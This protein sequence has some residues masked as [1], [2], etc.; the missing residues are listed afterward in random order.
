L[1]EVIEALAVELDCVSRH[2]QPYSFAL[3]QKV[4]IGKA[5]VLRLLTYTLAH[6]S[7]SL[8]LLQIVNTTINYLVFADQLSDDAL[9][10]RDDY[11]AG[12]YTLPVVLAANIAGASL[13]EVA[14]WG[15]NKL[16]TRLE[17]DGLLV[18]M[19]EQAVAVLAEALG[20][21]NAA[22]LRHTK[23]ADFLTERHNLMQRQVRYRHAIRFTSGLLQALNK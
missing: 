10:W 3:M 16:E 5:S 20:K 12:R 6:A 18:L 19:A 22:D 14:Q 23:W 2:T 11:Q 8:H 13:D 1:A 7:G 15:S 21:L 9:D 4:C 17:Q